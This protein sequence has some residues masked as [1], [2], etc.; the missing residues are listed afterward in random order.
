MELDVTTSAE[1][2]GHK[3][4]TA[5]VVP[6]PIAWITT[7]STA[8]LVN[9]AP[10]S[11]YN[12]VGS[13]PPLLAFGISDD[14][15][16]FRNVQSQ[17]EL[18][19]N[20]VPFAAREA[21]NRSAASFPPDTSEVAALGLEVA[22]AASVRPPRLVISP[23]HLEC[24]L[25]KIVDVEG[26]PI[27]IARVVHVHVDDRFFDQERNRI[28][29]PEL[30]LIGRMHGRGFYARTTECFDMPRVGTDGLPE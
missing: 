17:G 20:V 12:A 10:F 18:V 21:M 4:L 1:E 27:V 14:S 26:S 24:R 15:D 28:R 19:V 16:T 23:A 22:P 29:T 11:F 9:A 2:L 7:V 6:R 30:D 13:S 3:I 25:A 5:L 8:G